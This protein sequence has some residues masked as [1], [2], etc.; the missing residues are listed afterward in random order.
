M[1]NITFAWELFPNKSS[2]SLKREKSIIIQILTISNCICTV[3]DQFVTISLSMPVLSTSFIYQQCLP[4]HSEILIQFGEMSVDENIV[5][6]FN[7]STNKQCRRN[8]GQ[9]NGDENING[10]QKPI[11]KANSGP[12]LDLMTE[13]NYNSVLIV[14][15]KTALFALHCTI[16]YHIV[17]FF[18]EMHRHSSK[19]TFF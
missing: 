3:W 7:M 2:F 19:C 11:H 10:D 14:D 5:S 17:R 9:S 4:R 8:R 1:F 18:T 13:P 16:Y 6:D 12:N 15:R